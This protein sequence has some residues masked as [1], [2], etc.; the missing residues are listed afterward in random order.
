M[1]QK[2]SKLDKAA[3]S[4]FIAFI[5]ILLLI[6]GGGLIM[7]ILFSGFIAITITPL[8]NKLESWG[9]GRAISALI[10]VVLGTVILVGIVSLIS[11]KSTD[12]ITDLDLVKK[13]NE[14]EFMNSQSSLEA[15]ID[16]RL[17]DYKSMFYNSL[18]GV[19][20][21]LLNLGESAV[22]SLKDM[23]VFLI[24]CPIYIFFMLMYRSNVGD[25]TLEYLKGSSINNPQDLIS[26]IQKVILQYLKGLSLLILIISTLTGLGLFFLGIKHAFIIGIISG[27]LTLIPFVGVIISALIPLIIALAT[28]DSIW[29]SVGVVAVYAVVQF[30]EGNVIT[31]KVVGNSININPLVVIISLVIMGALTGIIG[32]ILTLPILAILKVITNHYPELRPWKILLQDKE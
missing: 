7:P 2:S 28:K 17:G 20:N 11:V 21:T 15:E 6:Y 30:L 10:T 16:S 4:I 9:I 32:M 1:T 25:F 26:G 12:I 24:T 8:A 22:V 3:K 5:L 18:E 29:Y 13:V 19:K 31:P 14:L 27:I 23:L